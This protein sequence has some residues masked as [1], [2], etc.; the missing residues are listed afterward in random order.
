MKVGDIYKIRWKPEFRKKYPN[1]DFHW[2]FEGLGVVKE[3]REGALYLA[4]TYWGH[5]GSS[6]K[7]FYLDDNY[8]IDYEYYF[9]PSD[10]EKIKNPE[11][12]EPDEVYRISSQHGCSRNCIQYYVK[13]GTQRSKRVMIENKKQE[14]KDCE[15]SINYKTRE[16]EHLKRK[17]EELQR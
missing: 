3:G 15:W 14:I 2:C 6:G 10:C 9:T 12:Y 1:R 17:L 8:K 4:D 7:A 16:L 11:D 5:N 13:K